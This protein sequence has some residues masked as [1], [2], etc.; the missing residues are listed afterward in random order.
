MENRKNNLRDL[1]VNN[2]R[3]KQRKAMR[4]IEKHAKSIRL[5]L[6]RKK[7]VSNHNLWRI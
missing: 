7:I 2:P 6:A 3:A 4:E 1:I 5:S